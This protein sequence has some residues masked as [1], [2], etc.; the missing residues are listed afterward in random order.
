[1]CLVSVYSTL[2][3]CKAHPTRGSATKGIFNLLLAKG[4]RVTLTGHRN[5]YQV[6]APNC[7]NFTLQQ[8]GCDSHLLNQ[9]QTAAFAEDKPCQR[10]PSWEGHSISS[11]SLCFPTTKQFLERLLAIS[12]PVWA[13][14]LFLLT[15]RMSQSITIL[16]WGSCLPIWALQAVQVMTVWQSQSNWCWRESPC[17]WRPELHITGR[18]GC[19]GSH[20]VEFLMSPKMNLLNSSDPHFSITCFHSGFHPPWYP[21]FLKM[22]SLELQQHSPKHHHT[23]YS[24]WSEFLLWPE[25]CSSFVSSDGALPQ[26]CHPSSKLPS[27]GICQLENSQ[28]CFMW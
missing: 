18:S 27:P 28:L 12:G 17:A 7:L 2:S 1:M 5:W 21:K 15:H 19:P 9:K 23:G 24:L 10:L 13:S 3:W 4:I 14:N 25:R 11:R 6:T 20:P 22:T 26:E 16:Q 8:L